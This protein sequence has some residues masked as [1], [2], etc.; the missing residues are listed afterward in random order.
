MTSR[1]EMVENCFSSTVA[2]EEA[3]VSGLAPGSTARHL[4]GGRVEHRQRGDGD[5]AVGEDAGDH[6]GRRQQ[7]GH[8]RPADEC[9]GDVHAQRGPQAGFS[10]RASRSLRGWSLAGSSAVS[11]PLR[12]ASATTPP[13]PQVLRAL[14][15]DARAGL[16]AVDHRE[17]LLEVGER[18]VAL[19]D[20]VV[21]AHDVHEALVGAGLHRLRGHHRRVAEGARRDRHGHEH[22][23]P[24]LR[25]RVLE[26]RLEAD[27]AGRGVDGVVDED[28]L[29]GELLARLR[30]G[31]APR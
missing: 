10:P 25:L 13:G 31:G 6:G 8:D 4:D 1:L 7:H 30:H 17:A 14:D 23:R 20:L 27:G 24:E 5:A 15:H 19:R 28:H 21:G 18:H 9:F 16:D 12:S 22:A 26:L 3:I 2:T 29:A 11:G